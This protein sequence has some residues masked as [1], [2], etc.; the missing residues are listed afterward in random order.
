MTRV[1]KL[2]VFMAIFIVGKIMFRIIC[3]FSMCTLASCTPIRDRNTYNL[4]LVYIEQGLERQ[5]EIVLE[6]IKSTCCNE[7]EFTD[8]LECN[9]MVDTYVTIKERTPYHLAMMRYLGRL[10]EERP[11]PPKVVV[12]GALLCE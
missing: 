2:L 7:Q 12:E 6:H 5:G 3:L 11:K 4:E 9:S 10:T 8:S 1:V